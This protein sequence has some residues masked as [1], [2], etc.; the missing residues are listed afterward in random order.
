MSEPE[1]PDVPLGDVLGDVPL[2]RELQRVI[3]SSTGPINWE[4]A[5]QVGITMASW[6]A[7]DPAPTDEDR[8]M[9]ADTVRA[10]E[11]AVADLTAL[12]SPTDLAEVQ[13]VRRAKWVE[14]SIEGL[15]PMLE[16]MAQKVTAALA[17]TRGTTLPLDVA[18]TPNEMLEL[19]MDKMV[20][21]LLGTQVGSAL[22]A[23]GQRVLGLY[24]LAVPRTGPRL[25]FVISNIATFER[26]WSLDVREFRA[27][28]ALHEVTH[29]F[30]FA[31][32]WVHPHALQ[33]VTDMVEH[34]TIDLAGLQ[35]RMEGMDLANPNALS[36]AFEGLGSLF[37]QAAD[38]EQRLRIARVQ[39]FLAAAESYGDHVHEALAA[40]MLPSSTRIEEAVLRFREGR[41]ADRALEQLLGVEMTPE[42][43]RL[44]RDFCA[45]VVAL[46]DL[47]TLSRMWGS[48]DS[49]PSMPELDEPTLWLSRMA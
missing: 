49:L 26:E 9:L 24:D 42:Q 28:V 22:G 12:P 13:A 36:D 47:A 30:E 10:A 33:L 3:M 37:G 14:A 23:L 19:L 31:Q 29:R 21:L 2:F 32:P 35:D 16:P 44:G 4:L 20:P 27:W 39:A 38:D 5:R 45:R 17:E 8:R 43:Y 25:L 34:A 6:G 41:P 15:R 1:Q 48:A 40:K 11:L 7:E 18:G 46:T